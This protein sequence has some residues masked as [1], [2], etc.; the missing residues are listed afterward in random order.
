MASSSAAVAGGGSSSS[1]PTEN[2]QHHASSPKQSTA[3]SS[4]HVVPPPVSGRTRR[5]RLLHC[6]QKTITAINA[7][8]PA[9]Q[10][11]IED[12]TSTSQ[13]TKQLK[14]LRK[15]QKKNSNKDD[16]DVKEESSSS[17]KK[18]YNNN[19][20]NNNIQLQDELWK[21]IVIE[22]T[23]RMIASSYA[24][25]LL[26]LSFTVQLH[27]ISGNRTTLLAQQQDT[28]NASSSTSTEVAQGML[29]QSH[30]YLLEE[31][32]P[33]LVSTIRRSVESV[34]LQNESMDWTKPTQ[35]LTQNDIQQVLYK[36]LPRVLKYGS[37]AKSSSMDNNVPPSP[38][39]NWIRFV[40]P[41]EECFDPIWDICSSPV[42]EDAQEQVLETI[43]YKLLLE[44]DIDGWKQLFADTTTSQQQP[45]AKVVAQFKKASN[46]VFTK[47]ISTT[48]SQ[49][50]S[51][52]SGLSSSWSSAG[53]SS[54]TYNSSFAARLQKLPTVLELGDVSFQQPS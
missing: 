5:Q 12:L 19:N 29:L 35:F 54:S 25:T 42:W 23:T 34:L 46:L 21:H 31:G 28:N 32:I 2:R 24:Y 38:S 20:N 37:S 41:D 50:Q 17:K 45:V 14:E 27:W 15:K 9:I 8:L 16:D 33:L 53:S 18:D 1:V 13:T 47:G 4:P 7:C 52:Q 6:R 48:T 26:F 44:D 43:W 51:H 10:P 30:Q 22:T 36:Q 40:L 49:E 39:R 3:R 11:I